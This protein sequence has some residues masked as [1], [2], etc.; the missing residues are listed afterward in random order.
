MTNKIDKTIKIYIVDDN[1]SVNHSLKFLF[2]AMYDIDIE[3]FNDPLLFLDVFSSDCRGCVIIDLFMPILNG[4]ELL[5]EMNRR[6]NNLSVMMMSGNASKDV[7]QQLIGAGVHAFIAKPFDMERLLEQVDESLR[8]MAFH[9]PRKD[10]MGSK[11]A[12]RFAG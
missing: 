4:H 12:A 6:G 7:V 3:T 5:Q 2:N 11:C 10:T 8:A 9:S 1:E